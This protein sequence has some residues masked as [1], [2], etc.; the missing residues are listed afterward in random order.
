MKKVLVFILLAAGSGCANIDFNSG[1]NG[2]VYYE[3][4][5]YLFYTV[6][7]KCVRS[8][9]VVTLPGKKRHLDF[10]S[11]YG[12]SSL[13]AEFSNGLLSKVGQTSDS[14][15]TETLTAIAGL[16]TAGVFSADSDGGCPI[17]SVLYPIEDGV[18]NLDKPLTLIR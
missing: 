14:K 3:P 5:P 2:A 9:K 11:G 7:K 10:S 8:A 4:L 6:S 16:E 15:I 12:S 18:P 1:E 13:S 17:E